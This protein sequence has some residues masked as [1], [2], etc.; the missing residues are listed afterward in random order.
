MFP[1]HV[2]LL[3][4]DFS[5]TLFKLKVHY[6]NVAEKQGENMYHIYD[7]FFPDNPHLRF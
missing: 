2:G 6:D 1:V 5:S 3:L 7:K 4:D